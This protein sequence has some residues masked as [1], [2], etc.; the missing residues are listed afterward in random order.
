MTN[1]SPKRGGARRSVIQQSRQ[2][3]NERIEVCK[4]AEVGDDALVV[5]LGVTVY[6]KVTESNRL[7][8]PLGEVSV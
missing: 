4:A 5:D 7:G 1:E 6:E 2:G 8:H 3:G